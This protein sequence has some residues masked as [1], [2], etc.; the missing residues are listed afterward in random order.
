MQRQAGKGLKGG[1]PL[2]RTRPRR[3]DAHP[4]A[5]GGHAVNAVGGVELIAATST[6]SGLTVACEL[7]SNAY[8]KGIKIND[9]E[10][11]SLNIEANHFHPDWNYIISPRDQ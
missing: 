8:H 6:T 9:A 10:L 5:V 1:G 3:T 11:K 4:A 7:D 2:Y